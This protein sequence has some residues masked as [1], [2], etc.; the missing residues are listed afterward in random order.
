MAILDQRPVKNRALLVKK[1]REIETE[2]RSSIPCNRTEH[3]ER[4]EY[5][6]D[7]IERKHYNR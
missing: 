1:N 6:D 5:L 2:L 4:P 3:M 7:Q